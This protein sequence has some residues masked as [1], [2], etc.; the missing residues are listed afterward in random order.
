ME[1]I[2]QVAGIFGM[3][4]NV[5]SYQEKNNK[6]VFLW[7]AIGGLMFFVNFILI[8]A[9][10][11]ALYNLTNLVRGLLLSQ[12]DRKIWRV[13]LINVL[14][15]I[16]LGVSLFFLCRDPAVS[17]LPFQ[18][19]LSVVPFITLVIMTVL[20]WLGNGKHI[21]LGQLLASSPSWIFHNIF[22]FSLGGIL[23]E[24]FMMCSVIVSF[25]RYRKD[26]FEK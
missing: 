6:R 11:G 13:S 17:N 19:V 12:N 14:Y 20:M 22:N 26:G 24:A 18:I 8:G 9:W 23:C 4:L 16:A 10:A 21:R 2:A 7:Q 25:I 5:Y 15:T 3:L 1:I